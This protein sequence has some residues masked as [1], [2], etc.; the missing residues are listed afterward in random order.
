MWLALA[1]A[2]PAG[3]DDCGRYLRQGKPLIEAPVMVIE[4]CMRTGSAQAIATGVVAGIA[5]AAIAQAVARVLRP[6]P[7]APQPSEP[8]LEEEAEG[9]EPLEPDVGGGAIPGESLPDRD[10]SLAPPST[11]PP[12]GE[13]IPRPRRPVPLHPHDPD[14]DPPLEE[15]DAKWVNEGLIWDPDQQVFRRPRPEEVPRPEDAPEEPAPVEQARPRNETPVPCLGIYDEYAKAQARAIGLASRI[16]E[17]ARRY[18]AAQDHLTRQLAKLTLRTGWDVGDLMGA[19]A[20]SIGDMKQ[21]TRSRGLGTRDTWKGPAVPSGVLRQAV[22]AAT[23][24]VR[25][26]TGRLTQLAGELADLVPRV[27]GLQNL[28]DEFAGKVRT[29]RDQIAH[30]RA[31]IVGGESRIR[32]LAA[33]LEAKTGA[34]AERVATARG[35]LKASTDQAR[36]LEQLVERARTAERLRQTERQAYRAWEEGLARLKRSTEIEEALERARAVKA[37]HQPVIAEAEREIHRLIEQRGA[38]EMTDPEYAELTRKMMELEARDVRAQRTIDAAEALVDAAYRRQREAG[39][40]LQ[41]AAEKWDA[42]QRALQPYEHIVSPEAAAEQLAAARRTAEAAQHDL[43]TALRAQSLPQAES[44]AIREAEQEIARHREILETWEGAARDEERNA[45]TAGRELREL[46]TVR[47][48]KELEHDRLRQELADAETELSR[49]SQQRESLPAPGESWT[50]FLL[51]P[52]R[53]AGQ[54]WEKMFGGGQ[55]PEEVARILTA[56]REAV[57]QRLD[58]LNALQA[59]RDQAMT[60]IQILKSQLDA[61]VAR[62]GR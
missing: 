21:L 62:H 4:D 47:G 55:S 48:I 3:A 18:R 52:V 6:R 61:C 25:E 28:A 56:A 14:W 13:G 53:W 33:E 26:L 39:E 35:G 30:L 32:Q 19:G 60:D 45:L 59:E 36:H 7:E 8:D 20:G 11:E 12:Y 37:E 22:E 16:E 44:Q 34:A 5:G 24:R 43:D 42:A 9:G 27:K 1:L 50:D 17:A 31:R 15:Q 57:Q 10:R 51:T 46:E 29:L 23:A 38:Y 58:A 41:E 49:L 40:A 2:G 54:A